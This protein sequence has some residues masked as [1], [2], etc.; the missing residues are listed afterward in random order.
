MRPSRSTSKKTTTGVKHDQGKD[1]WHL[2]PVD[3]TREIVRVLT[4]GAKKYTERNWE[5]GLLYSRPYSA[6]L[7]HL[8]A[9]WD[10]ED[11]D[12][13]TGLSHLAHAGCC[14]LFLLS[15]EVRQMRSLDNRPHT[16][17]VRGSQGNSRH[18]KGT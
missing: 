9:W 15:Y 3:S 16:W 11:K 8:T 1:L 18:T 6:L 17:R 14:V 7:R 13:E 2:L 10:G 12:P 5:N 4:F